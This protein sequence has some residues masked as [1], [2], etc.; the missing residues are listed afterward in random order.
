MDF[1]GIT[2]PEDEDSRSRWI[3][4]GLALLIHVGV[5]GGMLLFA[6]LAPEELKDDL[7][8]VRILNEPPAQKTD[9]APARRVLAERRSPVFQPQAQ[10]VK[11]QVVNP[12]VVARTSPQVAAR[13]IEMKSVS[14]VA[15]PQQ[16]TR[17]AV[18][19]E[20]VATVRSAAPQAVAGRVD[21]QAN[22]GPALRGPIEVEEISRDG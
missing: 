10:A 2:F 14:R 18:V 8:P 6:W 21:V 13:S 7:I 19:V 1:P 12:R 16:V 22:A 5:F 17:S 11:P 15:A 9:P 4:S 20:K 3:S